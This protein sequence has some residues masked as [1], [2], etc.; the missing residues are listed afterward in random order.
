MRVTWK[1]DQLTP[2]F[3]YTI[4]VLNRYENDPETF[5][6]GWKK[7]IIPLCSWTCQTVRTVN[8]GNVEIGSSYV[9]RI[10]K[11]P[12][13]KPYKE[14]LKTLDGFTLSTGDY[15]IKGEVTEE[16]T[17]SNIITLMEKYRPDAFEIRTV[18]DNTG[19]IE[20]LEHY[21]VEGI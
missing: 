15:V 17:P 20:A 3:D 5:G 21:R 12:D 4:T 1:K 6:D 7:T 14:W 2:T 10:P 13:Y 19:I 9:V 18:K 16:V 11:N 8:N